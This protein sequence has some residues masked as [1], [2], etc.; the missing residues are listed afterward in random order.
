MQYKRH[1]H[2]GQKKDMSLVYDAIK[3]SFTW[4]VFC[5]NYSE[6]NVY[7]NVSGYALGL[8]VFVF[9]EISIC[10]FITASS[11]TKLC[12]GTIEL[13]ITNPTLYQMYH[14]FRIEVKVFLYW[15]KFAWMFTF[16]STCIFHVTLLFFHRMLRMV[17]QIYF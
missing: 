6:G 14:H 3:I 11:S 12:P 8:I 7:E 15:I 10:A 16:E 17:H 9:S 2:Q 13:L 5:Y 1:V 4:E